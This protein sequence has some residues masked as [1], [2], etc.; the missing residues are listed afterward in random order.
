MET[1]AQAASWKKELLEAP[2]MSDL[3]LNL[4]LNPIWSCYPSTLQLLEAISVQMGVTSSL[5]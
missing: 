4:R 3:C 5:S 2:P 1:K